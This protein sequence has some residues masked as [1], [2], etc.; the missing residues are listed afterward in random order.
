[1]YVETIPTEN[2][3]LPIQTAHARDEDLGRILCV[4]LI[5]ATIIT[6]AMY[7]WYLVS[8]AWA[9]DPVP[10]WP[11]LL[12][13]L[14][15]MA[16]LAV[17]HMN[18]NRWINTPISIEDAERLTG[19]VQALITWEIADQMPPLAGTID[20]ITN[21]DLQDW[22]ASTNDL[23]TKLRVNTLNRLIERPQTMREAAS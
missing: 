19:L 5:V 12:I 10:P 16:F 20:E 18:R 17:R 8:P 2:G 1:M 13:A 15:L 3:S 7:V 21:G 14:A 23:L 11:V 6:G 9:G 4:F 22:C